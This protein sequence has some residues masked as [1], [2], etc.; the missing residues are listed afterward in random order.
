[1]FMCPAGTTIDSTVSPLYSRFN[2]H[3]KVCEAGW[4]CP[5]AQDQIT[6]NGATY[7]RGST[8]N[9]DGSTTTWTDGTCQLSTSATISSANYFQLDSIAVDD[10][11]TEA[12][13][14][15]KCLAYTT[16]VVTACEG[17]KSSSSTPGCY[18]IALPGTKLSTVGT[19]TTARC[20][21]LAWSNS[22][23]QGFV[24]PVQTEH[25]E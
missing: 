16:Q 5:T 21:V 2:D 6:S 18:A 25:Q 10:A 14:L 22:C 4:V 24:C 9:R 20:H 12:A 11:T 8:R 15:V 1:M 23:K 7:K 3:C 17:R 13:C 19:G